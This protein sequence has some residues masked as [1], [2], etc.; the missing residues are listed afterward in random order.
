[1]GA[2]AIRL[3]DYGKGMASEAVI[4]AC[5]TAAKAQGAVLIVDSKARGFGHYGGADIVKPNA[6]ELGRA[7]D[8]PTGTDAEI[9]AALAKALDLSQCRSILVTRSAK[10]M[11]LAVRG[12]PVRH[13]RRPPVEVFDASGA[14]DT[15]LAALGNALAAGAAIDEAIDLAMLA[16]AVAVTKAGTAIATPHEL[17]EAELAAHRAPADVKIVG[18]Q[19]MMAE[20]ARWRERGMK[21]GFTNGCFDILHPGHIAYLNQARGWCDRLIVGLNSDRSVR[22]IKGPGR[23][24]NRLEARAQV[25]AGLA[26]VD[27]VV[28]FDEDTPEALIA[29]AHPDILVKGGDYIDQGVVGQEMVTAY[30]GEVRLATYV[31]GHST[32]ATLR[33]FSGRP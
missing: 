10:G 7:T 17:V 25:L 20:V 9:E 13:F 23:P 22:E 29:A 12:E 32:T 18:A 24:V 33:R 1:M 14:G 27:L 31:K 8:L 28:P 3:S 2:K 11:S 30:G 26:C 16:S 6:A 4:A 5:L 19:A 15:A 21:I